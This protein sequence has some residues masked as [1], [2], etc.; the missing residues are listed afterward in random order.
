LLC[1]VYVGRL[2][3]A[4]NST[5][6]ASK[7]H[8]IWEDYI[9]EVQGTCGWMK[10][11][12]LGC[13]KKNQFDPAYRSYHLFMWKSRFFLLVNQQVQVGQGKKPSSRFC[14][15]SNILQLSVKFCSGFSSCR[16]KKISFN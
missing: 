2:H 9:L 13:A 3:A 6:F 5:V 15:Y 4:A 8:R 12:Y 14:V 10:M 16:F 1:L 7:A 11:V